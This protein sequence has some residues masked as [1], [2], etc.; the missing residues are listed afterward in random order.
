VVT[1]Q[2]SI[3]LPDLFRVIND[4]E[5]DENYSKLMNTIYDL[6][7]GNS[8]KLA[9]VSQQNRFIGQSRMFEVY[10]TE[11][12]SSIKILRDMPSCLQWINL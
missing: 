1:V 11:L 7:K 9:L 2:D 5:L 8:Y 6:W 4:Y 12:S 10:A 3:E